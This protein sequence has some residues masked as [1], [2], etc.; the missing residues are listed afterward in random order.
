MA[1]KKC[2]ECGQEIS[3]S[4]AACPRCGAK[5]AKSN[6][7]LLVIIIVV[8]FVVLGGVF[9]SISEGW[10][11]SAQQKAQRTETAEQEAIFAVKKDELLPL[12]R[13]LLARDDI[14]AA[15][16]LVAPIAKVKD[17]ALDAIRKDIAQRRKAKNEDEE[18]SKLTEEAKSVKADDVKKG[19]RIYSRLA[20]LVPDN[21]QYAEK[22]RKFADAK[23]KLQLKELKEVEIENR[24]KFARATEENFLKNGASATVTTKGSDATTLHIEYVLVSKAFAYQLQHNED[25]MAGC[26]KLGYKKI[27]LV[28]G[29]REGWVITL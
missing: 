19:D 6:G 10:Q 20:Q 28:D 18:L 23:F 26:R 12:L 15:E 2:R 11:R 21:K 24:K 3:T 1:L 4:A 27:E 8:G 14:E 17:P 22:A 16:K 9:N 29:F 7:C 5:P 25:F 13:A